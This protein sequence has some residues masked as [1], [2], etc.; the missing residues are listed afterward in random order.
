LCTTTKKKNAGK[1]PGH[2]QKILLVRA[3]STIDRLINERA[4]SYEKGKK[5]LLRG[6]AISYE[7]PWL[8]S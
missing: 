8:Q 5:M 2:A 3:E 6:Y 7:R 4:A 1:K